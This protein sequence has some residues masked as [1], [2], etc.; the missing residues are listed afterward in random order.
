M[1]GRDC[2]T[3]FSSI[4][5]QERVARGRQDLINIHQFQ[6]P[7]LDQTGRHLTLIRTSFHAFWRRFIAFQGS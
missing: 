3:R 2:W 7:P 1:I 4:L 6:P 5:R